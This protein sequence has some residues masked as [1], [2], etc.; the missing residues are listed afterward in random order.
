MTRVADFDLNQIPPLKAM[1]EGLEQ[2]MGYIPNSLYTMA[3]WPEMLGEFANLMITVMRSGEL[4]EGLKQLIALISSHTAGCR[5]CQAHTASGA[6]TNGVSEE[7]IQAVF[8]FEQSDLFDDRE[9]AALSLAWHASLQPNGV[10]ESD[11]EEAKRYFSDRQ[12]V[13]IMSVVGMFGFLNRWN[14]SFATTLEDKPTEFA[15]SKL[16]AKGWD[17]GGH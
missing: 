14:D 12:I 4:D 2:T 17:K 11:F 9:R 5:Y 1:A 3:H 8:E 15:A 13:E 6:A 16:S 10:E 7:K